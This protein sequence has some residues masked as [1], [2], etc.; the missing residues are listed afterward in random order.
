MRAPAPSELERPTRPGLIPTLGF[1][2]ATML[3]AGCVIGSGI[4]RK[5]GV[6]AAQIGSPVILLGVWVVAGLVSILGAMSNAE[7]AA[8]MPRTGGQYV[9]LRRAFGPFVG[10]L[11]GWAGMAV[12][13]TGAIAALTFVFAEYS[14][15]LFPLPEASASLAALAIHVPLIGDVTPLRDLGVKLLASSIIIGLTVVNYLG[16][17][18][19]GAVQNFCALAKIA[20]MAGLVIAVLLAPGVGDL[21]NLHTSSAV[22]HPMGFALLVAMAGAI[23]GAFWGYDGWYNVTFIAGE[24]RNPQRDLPRA[25]IVGILIVAFVY[26]TMSAIYAYV[27]PID[28]MAQSKLV[29]ADVAERVVAGGGKWI[30]VAVMLSTFGAAN[31]VIL[32][33]PRLY[34]SMSQDGLLPSRLGGAHP[35]YHTPAAALVMQATWS[36]VLL[37]SGTF[38]TLTDTLIFVSWFFYAANAAAVIVLRRREPDAPRP[39]RVPGYPWVPVVFVAFGLAYLVLTLA[40][41]IGAYRQAVAAGK[42]ALLNS[43]IGLALMISGTPVYL[44]YRSRKVAPVFDRRG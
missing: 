1:F 38:D 13:Q 22:I 28:V 10:F 3:V 34:Y 7:L 26:V 18:F 11:Y 27:L 5:P 32:T 9:F 20:A 25:L 31:A 19:G 30:A 36:I 14:T 15:R 16:V 37:F 4:F 8:M 12:I 39:F 21:A 2:S 44:Y 40:N 43:A 6:M 24:L 29:A 41:D 33:G 42:P 23:Q 35:R 17:R